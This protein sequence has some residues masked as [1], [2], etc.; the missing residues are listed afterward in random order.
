M[1]ENVPMSSNRSPPPSCSAA[2]LFGH[3]PEVLAGEQKI[4]SCNKYRHWAGAA[5]W[6]DPEWRSILSTRLS[7]YHVE[8][9]FVERRTGICTSSSSVLKQ[10]SPPLRLVP[11]WSPC[12][13][14]T[15]SGIRSRPELQILLLPPLPPLLGHR[16]DSSD[17]FCPKP[18]L[19]K[20]S[21][22]FASHFLNKISLNIKPDLLSRT[23]NKSVV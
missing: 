20:R 23:S 13:A 3:M 1:D 16:T 7:L 5:F 15:S 19:L 18:D 8:V 11:D 22:R 21:T 17:S 4:K 6:L 2:P 12:E 14:A 9:L 10:P